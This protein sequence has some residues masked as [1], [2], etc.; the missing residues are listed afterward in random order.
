MNSFLLFSLMMLAILRQNKKSHENS[1]L[2]FNHDGLH[3]F[4]SY[5]TVYTAMH[6]FISRA[7]ILFYFITFRIYHEPYRLYF[8][9]AES[10]AASKQPLGMAR[11]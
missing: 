3:Y 9:I 6:F 7:V 8:I 11:S 5:E 4:V 10:H 2:I 1:T